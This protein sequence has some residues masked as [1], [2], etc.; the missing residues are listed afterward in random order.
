M[1]MMLVVLLVVSLPIDD[2]V[3]IA[4]CLNWAC[5]NSILILFSSTP[6]NQYC[7]IDFQTDCF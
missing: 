4:V 1:M 3:A 5:L 6:E 7:Q 2:P